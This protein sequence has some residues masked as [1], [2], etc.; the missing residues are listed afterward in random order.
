MLVTT[1]CSTISSQTSKEP[2]AAERKVILHMEE[3]SHLDQPGALVR[4]PFSQILGKR[5]NLHAV[6]AEELLETC[7]QVY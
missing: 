4:Q 3:R 1:A 5:R 7:M 6:D 2:D